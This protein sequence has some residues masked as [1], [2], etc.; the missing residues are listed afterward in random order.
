VL[1]KKRWLLSGVIVLIIGS[2]MLVGKGFI[3]ASFIPSSD[4]GELLIQS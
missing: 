3:G 4:Q 1:N 2:V